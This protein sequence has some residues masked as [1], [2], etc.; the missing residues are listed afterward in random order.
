MSASQSAVRQKINAEAA[1]AARTRDD[2]GTCKSLPECPECGGLECLCRPRFF[3]GQLLTEED[4]NRL[5]HYI[6]EKNK[7]HNRY[8]HGSGVVC[9]LEVVCHPCPDRVTVRTGYALSPCGEDIVVCQDAVVNV[10]ELIQ[11]C[12]PATHAQDCDPFRNTGEENCQNLPETWV[13]AICY[14][15]KPSRGVT[16]LRGS[17]GTACCSRCNCGGSSACGCSCHTQGNVGKKNSNGCQSTQRNPPPQCEPTVTCEGYSFVAYKAPTNPVMGRENQPKGEWTR[18]YDKCSSALTAI[19]SSIDPGA[20]NQKKYTWFQEFKASLVD[21]FQE[22]PTYD[23]S[24]LENLNQITLTDPPDRGRVA[25]EKTFNLS[26]SRITALAAEYW[27]HCLCSTLL[28]PCPPPV[29]CNCVPLA[30][31]KVR[32]SDCHILEVCNWGPRRLVLT[33]PNLQ[34]WLSPLGS[35]ETLS[36]AI[37]KLCC[38]PFRERSLKLPAAALDVLTHSSPSMRVAPSETSKYPF[39]ALLSQTWMNKDR[40]IDAL[41]LMHAALGFTDETNKPLANK[42][43][44]ENALPFLLLNQVVR[45]TL[46]GVLPSEWTELMEVLAARKAAGSEEA[47]VSEQEIELKSLRNAVMKL[48]ETMQEQATLIDKLVESHSNNRHR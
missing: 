17:S 14:D 7:L 4:L 45:P 33:F 32:R 47:A 46:E 20:N 6:V 31:I 15:E 11:K 1:K 30:T 5:E 13:L 34:Y 39:A 36:T 18:R 23:C 29:E 43:E 27:V 48:Q 38:A 16:A 44:F 9:G 8:L 37:A 10:C 28:P 42:F 25:W 21:F 35:Q 40:T 3:A 19:L 12:R 22:Y 26:A 41:T 24:Y 2:P